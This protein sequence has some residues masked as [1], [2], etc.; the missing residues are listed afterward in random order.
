MADCIFCNIVEGKIQSKFVYQDSDYIII[1]DINPRA[2]VHMLVIPKKHVI[3]FMES[4]TGLLNKLLVLLKK[5]IKEKKVKNYRIVTNGDGAAF[6]DHFHV[7]LM[8]RIAKD[9]DL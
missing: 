8:G 6:I 4:D 9:R 3:D 5:I 7:H 2:P 1:N